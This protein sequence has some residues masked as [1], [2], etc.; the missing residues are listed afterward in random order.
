MRICLLDGDTLVYHAARACERVVDW[1]DDLVT[2]WADA[3]DGRDTLDALA[4]RIADGMNA[5]RVVVALSDYAHPNWRNAV[6]P[7]Y[8]MHREQKHQPTRRPLLWAK[9]REHFMN[10]ERYETLVRPGL[11][12]DDVLGIL[13]THP[14]LPVGAPED[15]EKIVVSIDKDLKTIPGF[16]CDFTRAATAF[17]WEVREVSQAGADYF[18]LYQTLIGDATDGYSGCPGVGPKT[19]EKVL[20]EFMQE[21]P[22]G[23]DGGDY[24]DVAGAWKAVVEQFTKKGLTESDALVQARVARI[25]RVDDFDYEAKGV[26]LWN[27]PR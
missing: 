1:G 21:D 16:H 3:Q 19:A 5:D 8:K 7:S 18:H 24:F 13:A 4:R 20:A 27:P 11:E 9:L 17:G 6:L 25:C 14:G 26:V 2:L 22:K 12:G 23:E 15:A 10:P